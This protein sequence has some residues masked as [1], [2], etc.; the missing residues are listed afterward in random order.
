[1]DA[2]ASCVRD[3][4]AGTNTVVPEPIN[5]HDGIDITTTVYQLTG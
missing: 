5:L 2:E 1:L 3:Q 4:P